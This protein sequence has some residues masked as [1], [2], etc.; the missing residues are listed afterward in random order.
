MRNLN[1]C[2]ITCL[3]TSVTFSSCNFR[4]DRN[5]REGITFYISSV[6]N[7]SHQGTSEDKAWKSIDKVNA[8]GFSPGDSVL[9]RGGDEFEGT[10]K[11]GSEDSGTEPEPLVISSY[12]AGKAVI[13]GGLQ[14]AIMADSCTYLSLENLELVGAGRKSGNTTDGLLAM[15]CMGISIVEVKVH[16]FQ[17]SGIHLHRCDDASITHVY[18]HEN[19]FAGIH[20]TGSTMQDPEKYD[21]HNLYI[22]YCVAENNPGDPTVLKNHSG[23]GILASSVRGGIIEYCEAFNNGWD[24]PWTGNGPVGI[25]IWD[26]NDFTIQFCI[27]HHNRTNP[28]AADG[29]GFDFDGGVSNSVIQYCISHNN[30]GAGFGLYEFGAAK[31]WE[32]NTIRYNISQD[33]G[34]INAGSMGI[35]KNDEGGVMR[36][37]DIYNNTFYNSL[38]EG[39][40]LWLYDNYPGFRFRNNVFVYNGSLTKGGKTIKDEVFQGNLYWNLAG[41]APFEGFKSL[42]EWANTTG[43]ENVEGRFAGF[44]LEP[45]FQNAGSLEV[46]DPE[47]IVPENLSGYIPV[48][49]SPLVN[50]GLDLKKLFGTD[51]GR[52]DILGRAIPAGGAF[53][54]GAI[55]FIQ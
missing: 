5:A 46:T 8:Y 10:I 35:W 22:G 50:N 51:P 23:N 41:E 47:M 48:A 55:E 42:V 30:E 27:A 29:G 16:G 21:N 34:I 52:Q 19:G 20:V 6:G 11:L 49:G 33:D 24:M 44:Y 39:S 36:N 17:K 4:L 15:N 31:P 32:N 12:G 54:I 14:N 18:A 7:D 9:F 45:Q 26:C 28:V 38:E 43:H 53:D 13:N 3:L 40:N 25:W 37:C 1:L 2:F